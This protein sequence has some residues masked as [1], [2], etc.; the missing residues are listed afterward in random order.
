KPSWWR[1]LL[2]LLAFV[3]WAPASL[4]G[5]PCAA[6]LILAPTSEPSVGTA[7]SA[8]GV[9]GGWRGWGGV[10]ETIAGMIGAVGAALLVV[11]RGRRGRLAAGTNAHLVP[12]AAAFVPVV[13]AGPAGHSP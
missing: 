12:A 7:G 2:A 6:L 10:S 9:A 4:V 5:L 3:L 8:S 1:L 11:G 13:V